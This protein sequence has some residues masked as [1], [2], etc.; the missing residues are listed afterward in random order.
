M[1]PYKPP[2]NNGRWEDM[3]YNML[4]QAGSDLPKGVIVMWSGAVNAIPDGWVLCD[5]TNGTPDLR[6][7]FVLGAGSTYAAGG[8]GGEERH[9]LTVDEMPQHLHSVSSAT[10]YD[11]YGGFMILS[12]KNDNAHNFATTRTDCS[13]GDR[14]HNNMPPYYALAYIMKL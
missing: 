6:G 11:G 14:P 7:R 12:P 3:I 8:T 1:L 5:G 9:T 2:P 4:P 10:S 13:G